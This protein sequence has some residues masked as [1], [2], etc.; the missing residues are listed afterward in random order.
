MISY[1][2]HIKGIKKVLLTDPVT[3]YFHSISQKEEELP[4]DTAW[5]F[6]NKFLTS[7]FKSYGRFL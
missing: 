1:A 7:G 5:K 2:Q 6:R 3:S 4:I